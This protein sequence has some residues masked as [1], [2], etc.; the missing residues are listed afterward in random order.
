MLVTR[1][2]TAGCPNQE[3]AQARH[4]I[5]TPPTESADGS[6]A[7]LLMTPARHG[8]DGFFVAHLTR[9]P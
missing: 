6:D 7:T 9:R 5:G 3:L 4:P 2:S 1:T 8:T